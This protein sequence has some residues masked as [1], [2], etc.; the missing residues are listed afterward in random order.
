MRGKPGAAFELSRPGGTYFYSFETAV[1]D[2]NGDGHL[3]LVP[4]STQPPA[5]LQILLGS[6]HGDFGALT[7]PGTY[8]FGWNDTFADLNGDGRPDLVWG[9]DFLTTILNTTPNALSVSSRS[10]VEQSKRTI[11]IASSS[12]SLCIRVEP[13]GDAFDPADVDPATLKLLSTGT[14]SVSEISAATTKS[15]TVGDTDGNN[16]AEYPACFAMS[17]VANLFSLLRGKQDA[18]VT[19][20]GR[21][22]DGRRICSRAVLPVVGTGNPQT[23]ARIDPNPLNPEGV[24]RFATTTPGSVTIRVFDVHGRLARTIWNAR[25]TATG[26]QEARIDGRDSAGRELRSGVYFFRIE[27]AG[28]SETGRFTILK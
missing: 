2:W 27:G 11:P 23:A 24:L 16:V 8:G 25:S 19:I 1:G 3:D 22:L 4:A 6:G 9:G 13:I 14:G 17:D 7:V 12:A 26:P 28:M 15:A 20:E 21:L 18:E 10:F 5:G